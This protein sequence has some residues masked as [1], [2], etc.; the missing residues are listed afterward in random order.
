MLSLEKQNKCIAQ[1]VPIVDEYRHSFM[2]QKHPSTLFVE[3]AVYKEDIT[4]S[5]ARYCYK[6]DADIK[7]AKLMFDELNEVLPPDNGQ[8]Y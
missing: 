3:D 7:F 1:L 5:A 6:M 4:V 8:P 2:H